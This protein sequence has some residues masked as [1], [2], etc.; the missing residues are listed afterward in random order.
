LFTAYKSKN[1]SIS[2]YVKK[3]KFSNKHPDF[4]MYEILTSSTLRTVVFQKDFEIASL[5]RN[6]VFES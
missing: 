2:N 4:I 6:D 3:F 1:T 5:R